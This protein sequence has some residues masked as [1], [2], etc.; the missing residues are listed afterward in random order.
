MTASA[1]DLESL[2]RRL[3]GEWTTEATHPVY[4]STVVQGKATVEWL[5]G[6]RATLDDPHDPTAADTAV[7]PGAGQTAYP[8]TTSE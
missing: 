7:A 3:V 4:P 2:G 5:E 1:T 8:L 6:K